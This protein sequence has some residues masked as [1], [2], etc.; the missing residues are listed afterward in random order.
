MDLI[1]LLIIFAIGIIVFL[2]TLENKNKPKRDE[3]LIGQFYENLSIKELDKLSDEYSIINDILIEYD[4]RTTQIDHIVVSPYG[5]FVIETKGYKGWIIGSENREF[6][7]QNIFGNSFKFYNPI[8]QNENHIKRLKKILKL[9]S[10]TPFI[11]I[12]AFND[13]AIL[14]IK[15]D[16]H[17]VVKISEIVDTI[18]KYNNIAIGSDE[19]SSIKN[20]LKKYKNNDSDKLEQH[21]KYVNEIKVRRDKMVEEG[22]CPICGGKL[23]LR[24]SS[25][26]KFL[27][28]SNYPKCKTTIKI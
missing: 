26:G 3:E 5:I 18:K 25:Y 10:D 19:Q 7:V 23:V 2:I 13:S 15:T 16:N 8:K 4:G 17:I 27:G 24:R 1:I 21:K 20:I 14:K 22:V 6:W 12:V 28:C 9:S 11:S